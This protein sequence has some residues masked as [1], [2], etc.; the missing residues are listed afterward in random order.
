MNMSHNLFNTLQSFSPNSGKTGQ[1][2]SLPQ[3]EKEGVG[4]ISRLP[5]SIR[6][7]LE[8]VLRN[9][10]GQKITEEDVRAIASWQAKGERT[11][12]VPFVVARVL[13][14]DFT[15]VPLLVDL[16]A[17]RSAVVR[18]GKNTGVIE[19]LVSVD[20][21]IDHSVQVDFSSTKDAFEKNMEMEFKRN[22]SR[23]QF[24]KWGTQAFD[25]F[26]VIPPGIGICHQV[27]LE[28]LAK[29][30]WEKDGVYFPDTLVGTD[31]HTTMINGLGII[32][33]GVGGIEAEAAMLGQPVYFLTPDVVG[34]NLTGSLREGVT[35]TDLV[36]RVTEMLRRKGVVGKF[37]EFF[38][39]GLSQLGLADRAT[40]A[41]MAPEYGATIAFFP[42]DAETLNYLR[43][44]GRPPDLVNL[45]EAYTKEQGLFRTDA[46]A[47]PIF[48]D[49]IE[50][51][52]G[53]VVPS[54][55]GP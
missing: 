39:S 34:V 3:L 17:M 54:L 13:L 44:T 18:L 5:V 46:T 33:W 15:G 52:L 32:G 45:V 47:D 48:S 28:Y 26:C 1:F 14:Q 55:A 36:L 37:V 41:N 19:P 31:S 9:F 8:S 24:L 21:V 40:V 38:G 22:N 29:S 25:G 7:V 50:L 2:Y 42:V 43:F 4:K 6:I 10:D 30:V 23:Y 20:L 53:T 27:N 16:A 12:E 11:E 49:V 51:D 35:A